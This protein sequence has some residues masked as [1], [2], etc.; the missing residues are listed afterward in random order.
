MRSAPT[1]SW[2]QRLMSH[3]VEIEL[4]KR[5]SRHNKTL[6]VS[7]VQ[8]RYQLSTAK[9]VYS[10]DDLYLNF[11]KAFREIRLPAEGAEVLV[12]GAG[13]ASVPL[14]L[15]K[16]FER[17]YR[18]TLVELD[19]LIIELASKYT[20][21]RL[22]SPVQMVHADAEHYVKIARQRFD[23]V[24]V[25][26]FVED[27]VPTYF[28][29]EAGCEAVRDL[30]GVRGLVLCNRLYATIKDKE[31][32]ECFYDSVFRMVYRDALRLDVGGNWIL[33]GSGSE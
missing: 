19:E 18:Y 16:S 12:L 13:L 23:L 17:R 28:S 32:T 2:W 15:E 9:S 22:D 10:F 14:I 31:Q 27:V 33:V 11:R 30:L 7:L 25:D 24:I 1:V 8:N 3:F 29:S 5:T 4:E 6:I 26:L 20:L 21:P